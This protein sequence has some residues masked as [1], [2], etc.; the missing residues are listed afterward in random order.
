MEQFTGT[1][2]G[3]FRWNICSGRHNPPQKFGLNCEEKHDFSLAK[4]TSNFGNNEE[5]IPSCFRRCNY[6]VKCGKKRS[7]NIF[8]K[9][10]AARE[11]GGKDSVP[12]NFQQFKSDFQLKMPN[13]SKCISF[14][15]FPFEKPIT[16]CGNAENYT[17]F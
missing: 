13:R 17:N 1:S 15:T 10:K 7:P 16:L 5:L 4:V 8:G 6:V 12:Q 3:S 9:L 11:I 2:N 14:H